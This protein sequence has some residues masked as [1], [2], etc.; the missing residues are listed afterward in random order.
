MSTMQEGCHFM[1][2]S[3][4][5]C[6]SFK[7]SLLFVG[8]GKRTFF[9]LKHK[10]KIKIKIILLYHYKKIKIIINGRNLKTS[11]NSLIHCFVCKLYRAKKI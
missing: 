4:H 7:L 3:Q 11:K 10:N 5:F 8:G 2:V 1:E 6:P 9:L